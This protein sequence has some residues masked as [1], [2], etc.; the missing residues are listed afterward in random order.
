MNIAVTELGFG[1]WGIGGL[2]VG[3]DTPIRGEEALGAY[4]D[5]GGN[6]IDTAAAYGESEAIIGK[7]LADRGVKDGVYV[8]TKTKNG[9][10]ADTLPG[11]RRDLERS[12]AK[13]RRDY[14]DIF[15]LHMPPEDDTV[16]DAAL[17][18]CEKLRAEGK[19]HGVGASIKGPAVTSETVD[20]CKKYVDTGRV[21]VI[22]LVYSILRQKNL[23]AIEYAHGRGVAIVARTAMESGF[24]TGKFRDGFRFPD[25]DHRQRWN[26]AVD[27]IVS[28][29]ERIKAKFMPPAYGSVGQLAVKFALIPEGVTSVIVGAKNATQQRANEEI[30]A[31][32]DPDAEIVQSLVAT[33]KG[34][35][36]Q[37]NPHE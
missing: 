17:G 34:F 33:F 15:Y 11:I 19:I 4:L 5:A 13:L 2:K 12:L 23:A 32:P 25:D 14:V 9:E 7:T 22:Q 8:A 29:V 3:A 20:L 28:A 27:G 21:D 18:E 30:A 26:D 6:F 35:T 31:L 10:F 16:I 36:G 1:A 24:L 37:C